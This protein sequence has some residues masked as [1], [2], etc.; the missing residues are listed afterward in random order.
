MKPIHIAL[1]AFGAAVFGFVGGVGLSL[2]GGLRETTVM[3]MAGMCMPVE[4]ALSAGLL[5]Q[6]E[7]E[8]LAT[9][10]G[11]EINEHHAELANT[12][13]DVQD[14]ENSKH[15]NDDFCT[16]FLSKVVQTVSFIRTSGEIHK[17]S[18]PPASF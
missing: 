4:T 5:T 8:A 14:V 15:I 2:L 3:R 18:L 16:G 9:S 17:H 1:I 10:I 13:K 6:V 12:F 7:A 11:Q